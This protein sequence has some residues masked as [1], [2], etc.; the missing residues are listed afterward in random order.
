MS[1][2]SLPPPPRRIGG[3]GCSLDEGGNKGFE[4]PNHIAMNFTMYEASPSDKYNKK[5]VKYWHCNR[6]VQ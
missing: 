1:S 2:T 6:D 5:A 4:K 3:F